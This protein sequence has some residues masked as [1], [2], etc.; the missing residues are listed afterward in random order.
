MT[1]VVS[2]RRSAPRTG[3]PRPE[4]ALEASIADLFSR[5]ERVLVGKFV[6]DPLGT[7][8]WFRDYNFPKLIQLSF[9]GTKAKASIAINH[10]RRKSSEADYS[11]DAY[12]A[13]TLFWIPDVIQNADAIYVNGHKRIAGDQVYVKRYAKAGSPLKVVFTQIDGDLNQRIVTTSFQTDDEGLKRFVNSPPMWSAKNA[14][15]SEAML[16]DIAATQEKP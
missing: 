9:R 2:I 3:A 13:K 14:S 16:L 10:L 6:E 11:F 4:Y 5:Y 12:R 15:S 1:K 7:R 8:V